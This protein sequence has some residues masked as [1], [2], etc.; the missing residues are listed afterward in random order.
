[1]KYSGYCCE[2]NVAV[3]S[4]LEQGP[5]CCLGMELRLEGGSL[6]AREDDD[7]NSIVCTL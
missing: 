6:G 5:E 3:S 1:M 7:N 2:E 4:G